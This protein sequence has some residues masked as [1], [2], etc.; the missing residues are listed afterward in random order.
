MRILIAGAF[1]AGVT[2]PIIVIWPGGVRALEDITWP[3]CPFSVSPEW[4]R[5]RQP[6]ALVGV[7]S[8]SFFAIAQ[9]AVQRRQKQSAA[10]FSA[11]DAPIHP[12]ERNPHR[13]GLSMQPARHARVADC[14]DIAQHVPLQPGKSSDA[15]INLLSADCSS[16]AARDL[17]IQLHVQMYANEASYLNTMDLRFMVQSFWGGENWKVFWRKR[18]EIHAWLRIH[19][20]NLIQYARWFDDV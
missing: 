5:R 9:C 6:W 17:I 18:F 2:P 14:I 12:Q 16:P 15:Y 8:H 19:F 7:L 1:S 10:L 13:L 3:R 11:A 4:H 20:Y